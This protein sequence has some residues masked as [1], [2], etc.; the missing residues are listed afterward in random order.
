MS[1]LCEEYDKFLS[2]NDERFKQL[3]KE[4]QF[5]MNAI[6]YGVKYYDLNRRIDKAIEYL[7]SDNYWVSQAKANDYLL[8]ILKGS[9]KE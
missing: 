1:N 8:D 3:S 9:D 5:Y 4:N 2:E 6:G 7:E